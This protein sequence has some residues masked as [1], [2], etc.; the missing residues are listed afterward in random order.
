MNNSAPYHVLVK[1]TNPRIENQSQSLIYCLH[2]RLSNEHRSFLITSHVSRMLN[3]NFKKIFSIS[4]FL[5]ELGLKWIQIQF[6]IYGYWI[7]SKNHQP[8]MAIAD[9]S[10]SSDE[11]NEDEIVSILWKHFYR[12]YEFKYSVSTPGLQLLLIPSHLRVEL[13]INP[14]ATFQIHYLFPDY[15][16]M[17]DQPNVHFCYSYKSYLLPVNWNLD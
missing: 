5:W 3:L 7:H 15:S 1:I 4:H 11:E 8:K 13:K 16:E 14:K 10:F 2:F 9:A 12:W 17:S 6:N